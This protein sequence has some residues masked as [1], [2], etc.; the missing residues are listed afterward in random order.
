MTTSTLD[1][2]NWCNQNSI[3][4]IS[5]DNPKDIESLILSSSLLLS[6]NKDTNI[7]IFK[8]THFFAPNNNGILDVVRAIASFLVNVLRK[9]TDNLK[10]LLNHPLSE[11]QTKVQWDC[12]YITQYAYLKKELYKV[13]I[14]FLTYI[15]NTYPNIIRADAIPEQISDTDVY[16]ELVTLLSN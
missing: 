15:V 14:S 11:D 10:S 3:C 9:N 6:E 12:S 2:I 7:P 16:T 13:Y 5:Y 4:S 1:I 8:Y